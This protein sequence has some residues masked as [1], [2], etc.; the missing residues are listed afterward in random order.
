[1]TRINGKFFAFV[2]EG[3]GDKTVARQRAVE[4]GELAGN[5]YVVLKGLSAGDRLIVSG[6]QKIG[7]GAPVA[8]NTGTGASAAT[9][10]PAG[11]AK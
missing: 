5:D 1:M 3:T 6:V 11:A 9:P 7:D 10:T 8:V 2:A 4:L